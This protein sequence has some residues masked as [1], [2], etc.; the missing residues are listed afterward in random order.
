MYSTQRILGLIT[1]LKKF[2]TV[3]F[4]KLWENSDA[5]CHGDERKWET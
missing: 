4:R 1:L 2:E 3:Q 5:V